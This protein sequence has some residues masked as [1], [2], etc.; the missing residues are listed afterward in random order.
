MNRGALA[1]AF[2]CLQ[3]GHSAGGDPTTPSPAP[4]ASE[5]EAGPA[6]CAAEA[7]APGVDPARLTPSMNSRQRLA[8]LES[9]RRI[10]SEESARALLAVQPS[11]ALER[12][13]IVAGRAW[14][15]SPSGARRLLVAL[16]DPDPAVR[17]AA[18][19]GIGLSG[20]MNWARPLGV[21]SSEGG[22]ASPAA[23]EAIGWLGG[24]WMFPELSAA[25]R[26]DVPGA[27]ESAAQ[28]LC[29]IRTDGALTL[30]ESVEGLPPCPREDR[31]EFASCELRRVS[32]GSLAHAIASAADRAKR[33]A[34]IPSLPTRW[35]RLAWTLSNPEP[36]DASGL[37]VRWLEELWR[38]HP[39]FT[40]ARVQALVSLPLGARESPRAGAISGAFP[41]QS[42]NAPPA[43]EPGH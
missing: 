17:N 20:E 33:E 15:G 27:R 11:N 19:I 4:P 3:C 8:I 14:A 43:I 29:R 2:F 21:L 1:L 30:R 28:A 10:G 41:G 18:G 38:L 25:L 26:S 40:N 9:W 36:N 22:P 31:P 35:E 42:G 6:P 5:A 7:I 37:A 23:I 39:A 24:G 34:E 16:G 12:H 32:P 13:A